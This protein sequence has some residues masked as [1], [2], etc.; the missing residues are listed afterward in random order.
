M[1][2]DD[3]RVT[4]QHYLRATRSAARQCS[5]VSVSRLHGCQIQL[6]CPEPPHARMAWLQWCS[7]TRPLHCKVFFCDGSVV[8]LRLRT[9]RTLRSLRRCSTLSWPT[10]LIDASLLVCHYQ[11]GALLPRSRSR[12]LCLSCAAGDI[13]RMR[14][15]G[16][17]HS[18]KNFAQSGSVIS[19]PPFG[20]RVSMCI[21]FE[22]CVWPRYHAA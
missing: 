5:I 11:V 14:T 4:V 9:A 19:P 21:E 7:T 20:R 12:S 16:D 8:Y 13:Y 17:L 1:R 10:P 22:P 6:R 2:T 15:I 3:S 18:L